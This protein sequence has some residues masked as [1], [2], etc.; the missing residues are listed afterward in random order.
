M[1]LISNRI[2]FNKIS[3]EKYDT[4]KYISTVSGD[5]L[6]CL[7]DKSEKDSNW[8]WSIYDQD[9]NIVRMG[10]QPSLLGAKKSCK[11]FL[12][13]EGVHFEKE[14]RFYSKSNKRVINSN[15]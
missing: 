5:V 6:W 8:I 4:P 11:Q 12:M 1:Q 9:K 3:N 15:C 13:K 14:I 10:T 2:K 7:V